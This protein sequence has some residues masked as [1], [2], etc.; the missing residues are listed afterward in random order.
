MR[1]STPFVITPSTDLLREHPYIKGMADSISSAYEKHLLVEEKHLQAIGQALW[2]AL[3]LG[4]DL[5]RAKQAAGQQVLPIIIETSDAALLT[6]PWE[7]LYHPIYGFLGRETGFS[8]SRHNPTVSVALPV[9]KCEP[10]RVLLFTSLPDDLDEQERLDVEAEQAAV[11]EALMEQERLGEVVLEMPDDG[12]LDTF[13][14]TLQAFQPHLVY[15]SGHGHFSLEHHHQQAYGSFLFEDAQGRG[16]SVTESELVACFQN[17]QV[18]LL[19]MSA[20]L[21][22][23]QHPSY[24][25]HGLSAALYKAG[26]PHVIGM[27]ESVF[28]VAGI[29]FAQALL[30][31]LGKRNPVDVALQ[32]ARAAI[33]QPFKEAGGYRDSSNPI[34]AEVSFGQ[35]CLPQLLSH[36]LQQGLVDWGFTPQPVKRSEWQVKRGD[37]S[38]PERFIGR[39]RELRL[40]QNRLRDKHQN[41]LLITGLGGMGKTALAGKLINR[42]E[43]DGY[44]VFTLYAGNLDWKKWRLQL[45]KSL[46]NERKEDFSLMKPELET[47]QEQN[48]YL[49]EL[50]LAQHDS[51]LALF[52]DN[53][54]SVQDPQFPHA[55]TDP[56]LQHWLQAARQFSKQ[57]LKLILTSRWR[58]P[59]WADS[60]HYA[61]GKPVYG[62]YVAMVRLQGLPLAG[63]RLQTAYATLGGNFRAL[64]FFAK[65]VQKMDAAEERGFM[66]AL[67]QASAE[68]QTDMALKMVVAQRSPVEKV[69][70]QRLLAYQ[71]PV[72]LLG[73]EIVGEEPSPPSPLARQTGEGE[74]ETVGRVLQHLL[75]VSLV[76]QYAN[77]RTGQTEYQLAPLVRSWLLANGVPEPD[78]A[79]LQKAAEFL[80]WELEERQ[81]TSWEHRL[82]THAALLAAKLTEP[83][84]RLVLRWIIGPLNRA[85]MYRTLLDD[86][87][88]PLLETDSLQ[89]RGEALNQIGKQYHHIGQYDTALDFLQQSLAIQQQIGGKLGISTTLSNLSQ[90]FKARGE[91]NTA[92]SYLQ[93][94]LAIQQ[95]IDD[96]LGIGTTL[97]NISQIYSARGDYDTALN[98]LKQSLAIQQQIGDKRGEGITLNN[99][100]GVY[101]VRGDY[102]TTLDFLK[103]SLTIQQQIGDKSDEGVVLNNISQIYHTRGDYNA[104]LQYLL[105]VLT[106]R[107]QIGDKSGEGTTLNN[108]SG[109]YSA[110]GDYDTALYYLNQALAIQQQIGDKR[111][112]GTTLNNISQIYDAC[113]DYDTAL[114]YLNQAR[115]IYQKIEYKEGEGAT[116][117]NISQIYHTRGD[118]D[119]ALYYL[120][121]VL[122]IYQKIE[123]KEG[124]GATLNN[125]SQ[126]Y[127][128]RGDYDT[129]FDFLK[130]SLTIQQQ[131]GNVTGLCATLFN[132][133]H[134]HLQNEEVNE[135]IQAWV[136][137]YR[138]AKQVNLAQALQALKNLA[139]QLGLEGGLQSWEK[140]AQKLE[141]APS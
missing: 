80:L 36:D 66:T 18:Q 25:H 132:I 125:I 70:L 88:P 100:S 56:T 11:Q 28:D 7:T 73:V 101:R 106:I 82:A 79:L 78:Q 68:S 105:Q 90:I 5:D 126:I 92:L 75:A 103:Q 109:V 83:A 9:V 122:A 17:T 139:E 61:L 50:V 23:K 19:V 10:L 6:L 59:D 84:Q 72:P 138:I 62:D 113:G 29:Q 97:N 102:D 104:A 135:A 137:V 13:R 4:D 93:Q 133:G 65:A 43:N 40:W 141:S 37:V 15:M 67:A 32:K 117:N 24:P 130:K 3:A 134:I 53:L 76:E 22:A 107:Q 57:G 26:I 99:I 81:N 129:A 91:Y 95:E 74:Q 64:E 41:R 21:S 16:Q 136:T 31:T 27:S 69:L 116:L 131:I 87:L 49:L 121:Q 96:K 33:T 140:L 54:E 123:H 114:Y 128:A 34:R 120:N 94:A 1:H 42:L 77:P 127:S 98:L 2:D 20:C 12:R 111:G 51:K 55:I 48:E 110:R 89:I 30:R 108:I 71:T 112:E 35:W 45:L 124:E 44:Q 38:L 118:Y 63:E 58:L 14:A 85:G 8:L 86:W 46:S 39:R 119:T 115:A 60:E 52:F 47:E